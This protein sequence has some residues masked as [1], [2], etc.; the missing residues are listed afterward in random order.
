M[1]IG[2]CLDFRPARF[3]KF[4]SP[5]A[6]TDPCFRENVLGLLG[7]AFDLLAQLSHVHVQVLDVRQWLP[8][9]GV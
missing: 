6:V 8:R 1:E 3:L 7:I 5:Q 4:R 9:S 2:V